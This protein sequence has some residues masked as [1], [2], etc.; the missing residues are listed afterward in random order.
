MRIRARSENARVY[1][2]FLYELRPS[3][4]ALQKDDLAQAGVHRRTRSAET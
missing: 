4:E 2:V 3:A 1:F